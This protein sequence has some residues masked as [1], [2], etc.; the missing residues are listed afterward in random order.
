MTST[1]EQIRGI[2]SKPVAERTIK[3]SQY[4]YSPHLRKIAAAHGLIDSSNP[5]ARASR[6]NIEAEQEKV[7]QAHQR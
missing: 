4:D 2:Y 5:Y 6:I 7:K 1:L 3:V